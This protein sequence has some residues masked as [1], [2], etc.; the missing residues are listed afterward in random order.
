MRRWNFAIWAKCPWAPNELAGV[1]SNSPREMTSLWYEMGYYGP[2]KIPCFLIVRL[3]EGALVNMK[4]AS[5]PGGDQS[6]CGEFFSFS[7]FYWLLPDKRK[8]PCV[9]CQGFLVSHLIVTS[10][11]GHKPGIQNGAVSWKPVELWLSDI[12]AQ[13]CINITVVPHFHW[14]PVQMS[15]I[16]RC[17]KWIS[18]PRWMEVKTASTHRTAHSS[19]LTVKVKQLSKGANWAKHQC[20]VEEL[21]MM[22]WR[23]CQT[24]ARWR[25][26][27]NISLLSSCLT[28]WIKINN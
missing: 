9:C 25:Q 5:A 1:A 14:L 26:H 19:L 27:S 22:G 8:R 15:N 13:S 10:T 16:S 24:A 28:G 11:R 2:P 3:W 6:D 21:G 18:L 7:F 17:V 4:M 12:P 23:N 20:G